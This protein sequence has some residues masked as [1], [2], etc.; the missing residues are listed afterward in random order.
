MVGDLVGAVLAD[1]GDADAALR[2]GGDVHAIPARR[3]DGDEAAALELAEH[4]A[5]EGHVVG[6]DRV[7]AAAGGE[8]ARR[9]RRGR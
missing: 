5:V 8:R 4:G 9:G 6:Q 7:G 2:G 3:R 1:R